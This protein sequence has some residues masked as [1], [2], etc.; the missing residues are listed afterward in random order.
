MTIQNLVGDGFWIPGLW[1]YMAGTMAITSTDGALLDADE[2]EVQFIGT[3]KID[4]GGSK[5]FGTS[6]SKIDWLAGASI[7]FASGSTVRVGVKKASSISTSA[8]PPARATIGAAA[9][10]VY[11]DLVGGT[12]TISSTTWRSD[13]MSAGT[14]FTVA[15]GDMLAVCF[16]LDTSSGTPSVKIRAGNTGSSILSP[17]TTL[18]TSGPTYTVQTSVPNLLITFDDGTLGW[19][20]GTFVRSVF[21]AASGSI[22]NTNINGNVFQVPYACKIDAIA[23]VVTT[24]GTTDFSLDLYSTPLGTPSLVEGVAVDANQLS[25]TSAPRLT[26]KQLTTPRTLT[27]NTDYAV[28]VRQTTA[29]AVTVHQYDVNDAAHFK[30]NGMGAECYAAISTAGA[31]FSAQNSGKRRYLVWARVCA[32]DDGAG[33]GGGLAANPIA[34]FVA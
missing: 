3:V 25:T 2:E 19:V 15:D 10:D 9:F 8:G 22:G 17:T 32:L 21:D 18:V 7:T 11:D 13:A 24:T 30:P 5:T 6:G 28:G 26:L 1:N 34:G 4:G 16:H 29:N 31:T 20:S 27:I 23:A 33:G 12:D 14:P